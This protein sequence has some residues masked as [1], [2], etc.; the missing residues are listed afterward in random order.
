MEVASC[1][2]KTLQQ[3]R[4][5]LSTETDSHQ[6]YRTLKVLSS[7]PTLADSLEEIGFRKTIRCLKRHK[8]L[9]PFA[10]D[11][12]AQW[13]EGTRLGLPPEQ[14]SEDLELDTSPMAE[15]N[16]T[17]P[18]QY[19]QKPAPWE[20]PKEAREVGEGSLSPCRGTDPH[21]EIAPRSPSHSPELSRVYSQGGTFGNLQLAAQSQVGGT[22]PRGTCCG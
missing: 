3:L 4:E 20:G 1:P 11:L 14:D 6:L 15:R 10:K 13:S 7:W 17:C 22:K 12:A 5:H 16:I 18:G 8:L 19:P 21:Q 2:P 9:G